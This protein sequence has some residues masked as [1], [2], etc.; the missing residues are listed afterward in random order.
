M[1]KSI[2]HEIAEVATWLTAADRTTLETFCRLK[3]M[4]RSDFMGMKSGHITAMNRLAGL[5]G[6][7]P[8]E[9]SR[10]KMPEA[11]KEDADDVFFG[12]ANSA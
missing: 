10:V 11:P 6:L 7:N 1:E 12:A 8:S 2:W 9:R 4:E 5:M 3:A